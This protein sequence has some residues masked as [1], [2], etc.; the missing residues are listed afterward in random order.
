MPLIEL[1]T[2]PTMS[3]EEKKEFIYNVTELTIKLLKI[4]PDKIQV[5][6][7]ELEKENWG[8]AGAV[9]SDAT[10]A[11]KS[12]VSDWETKE[13]YDT[14][15]RNVNGMAIIKI[16]IWNTFDQETKDK[17]VNELTQVTS[18]YTHAPL[19]KVLI[20]I[21]EMIPGNWGQSGVTGANADFLSK[22]RTF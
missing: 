6:I 20:L 5:L 21:R 16:D 8:K 3:T 11:E 15:G 12:R 10:F 1:N 18:K 17:W 2:W 22:S 14:P 4:V 13:S 7:T 9:A 19:D